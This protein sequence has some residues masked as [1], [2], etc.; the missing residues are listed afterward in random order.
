MEWEMMAKRKENVIK[1]EENDREVKDKITE[2][3]KYDWQELK[4][5]AI[6]V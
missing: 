5:K 3:L 2:G 6:K 1:G 4:E